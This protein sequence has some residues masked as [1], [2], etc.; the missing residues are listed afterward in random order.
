MKKILLLILL[1]S[2]VVLLGC[3][4]KS[5]VL[6]LATNEMVKKENSFNL[7]TFD[8][9]YN[10]SVGKIYTNLQEIK[11]IEYYEDYDFNLIESEFNRGNIVL[12]IVYF[13]SSS[14]GKPEVAGYKIK[15]NEIILLVT[16]SFDVV[17]GL[18]N[19]DIITSHFLVSVSNKNIT[20][21]SLGIKNTLY[22]TSGKSV[23][24][25]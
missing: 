21:I 15:N 17:V 14:D 1:F 23:Y 7:R 18:A 16:S 13:Y 11:D 2:A 20:Q 4:N 5:V 6:N 24:Y 19:M 9:R 25:Y 12:D 22:P 3:D 8:T 10:M